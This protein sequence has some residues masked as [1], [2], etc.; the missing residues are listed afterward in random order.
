MLIQKVSRFFGVGFCAGLCVTAVSFLAGCSTLSSVQMQLPA[1]LSE[2]SERVEVRGLQAGQTGSAEVD[3]QALQFKRK[4][5]QFE[6]G[7]VAAAN[8]DVEFTLAA[9]SDAATRTTCRMRQ[10]DI[11]VGDLFF[12][13]KPFAFQCTFSAPHDASLTLLEGNALS[14]ISLLQE[15][16]G[17]LRFQGRS[18]NVRSIHEGTGLAIASTKPLGYVIE[19]NGKAVSAVQISGTPMVYLPAKADNALRQASLQA[20]LALALLW[21]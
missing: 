4:A 18:L 8:S 20:T 5:V 3:G 12:N 2:N 21:E 14:R 9:P 19:E 11:N 10:R 13:A 17:E 7:N 6:L 15:R 1:G 16:R